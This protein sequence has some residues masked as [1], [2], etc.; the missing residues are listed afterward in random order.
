MWTLSTLQLILCL[1][2]CEHSNIN[3]NQRLQLDYWIQWPNAYKI[4]HLNGTFELLC[5]DLI[6]GGTPGAA[7]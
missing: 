2:T 6:P 5:P 7:L 1:T 4:C 3:N